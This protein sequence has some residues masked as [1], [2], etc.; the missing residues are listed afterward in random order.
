[1]QISRRKKDESEW[2]IDGKKESKT[3]QKD[4]VKKKRV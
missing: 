3:E 1:V 2:L 4:E